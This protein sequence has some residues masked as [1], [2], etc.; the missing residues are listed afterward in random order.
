M[1]AYNEMEQGQHGYSASEVMWGQGMNLPTDLTH[2]AMSE[3]EEDQHQF[4]KNIGKELKEIREKVQPFNQNKKKVAI[5]PFKEGDLILIHQQPRGRTHKLSPRWRGPFKVN[6]IP[7][8]F[9][10]QYE[11]EG[12]ET[13]MHVRSC[14]KFRGQAKCKE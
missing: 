5:N 2:G 7:N 13:I 12:R 8:P 14:K 9:Q 11:D 10:V 6:K 3:K 1:L 4:V